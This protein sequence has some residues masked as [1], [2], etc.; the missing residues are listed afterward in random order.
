MSSQ[1]PFRPDI[2]SRNIKLA[3]VFSVNRSGKLLLNCERKGHFMRNALMRFCSRQGLFSRVAVSK[4]RCHIT[5]RAEY[6]ESRSHRALREKTPNE[7]AKEIAASRD[8]IGSQ[9]A[10]NSP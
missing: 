9:T 8:L 3:L 10:E 6:N 7:F 4:N 1:F 5:R 2:V